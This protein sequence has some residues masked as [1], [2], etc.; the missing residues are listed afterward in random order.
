MIES[1]KAFS[2]RLYRILCSRLPEIDQWFA[3]Q[4]ES[5][6]NGTGLE[7]CKSGV[8]IRAR[9]IQDKAGPDQPGGTAETRLT[10]ETK[11]QSFTEPGI[12]LLGD[13]ALIGSHKPLIPSRLDPVSTYRSTPEARIQGTTARYA[14][15]FLR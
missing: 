1:L 2:G 6:V 14:R 8:V 7:I 9:A 13:R 10:P 4:I 15:C 5:A 11:P 12:G 3:M